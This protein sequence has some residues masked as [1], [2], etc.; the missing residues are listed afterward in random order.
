MT[1]EP[2]VPRDA[3]IR[4]PLDRELA[5]K[6]IEVER[7]KVN[8]AEGR[9][10]KSQVAAVLLI[11]GTILFAVSLGA[12]FGDWWITCAI[13]GAVSAIVGFLLSIDR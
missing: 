10:R 8:A 6:L 13:M 11:V 7:R 9:R 5:D 4:V 1:S 2:H 12:L 3:S